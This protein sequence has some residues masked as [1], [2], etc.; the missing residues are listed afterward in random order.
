M[1]ERPWVR[2]SV[3]E[4]LPDV[5]PGL[6]TLGL[7]L[8]ETVTSSPLDLPAPELD[9]EPLP[10]TLPTTLSRLAPSGKAAIFASSSCSCC[11]AFTNAAFS[12]F[13]CSALSAFFTLLVTHCSQI[14]FTFSPETKMDLDFD[15]NGKVH[16]NK[17]SRIL[18]TCVNFFHHR[19]K[20]SLSF[21][22]KSSCQQWVVVIIKS[23]S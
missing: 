6:V 10:A 21:I 19:A 22:Y 14:T 11:R 3:A 7:R 15:K 18:S 20:P 9:E 16:L 5:T 2:E 8:L 23:Q 12:L 13:V 17:Y 4:Y 1:F